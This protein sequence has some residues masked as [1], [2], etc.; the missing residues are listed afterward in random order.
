MDYQKAQGILCRDKT[1]GEYRHGLEN[2]GLLKSSKG[3]YLLAPGGLREL[4]I[5]IQQHGYIEAMTL[6][7]DRCGFA[8]FNWQ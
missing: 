3:I 2:Y 7:A 4:D 5:L 6:A 1:G 8:A